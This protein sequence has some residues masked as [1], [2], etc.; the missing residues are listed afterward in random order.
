MR[1]C[2]SS[3]L[4]LGALASVVAASG[5]EKVIGADFSA[6]H[7]AECTL[8][9]PPSAPAVRGAGGAVS[10]VAAAYSLE[11]G[12]AEPAA[13]QTPGYA[14]IGYD[15]DGLCTA[16]GDPP[17]CAPPAW[18]HHPV[19]D[20]PGG[21][22]NALG[23]QIGSQRQFFGA[24][25]LHSAD[26]NAATQRGS[27]APLLVVEVLGYAGLAEDDEVEVRAYLPATLPAG[28]DGGIVAPKWDGTDAFPIFAESYEGGVVT[29]DAGVG[30]AA[31]DGG[32]PPGAPRWVDR[33]A[34]V[35]HYGLVARFDPGPEISLLGVPL[36][37]SHALLTAT[38]VPM[39]G[40]VPPQWELH[41]ALLAGVSPQQGVL[42]FLPDVTEAIV[43]AH[44]CSGDP[45][46]PQIKTYACSFAD[47]S[48]GGGAAC[49]GLSF[50]ISFDLRRARIGPTLTRVRP[51]P[52]RPGEDPGD[53]DCAIPAAGH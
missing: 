20:G 49:D 29:D 47:T 23:A 16:A 19:L 34:Y 46:Y 32:P 18:T 9:V 41:D 7:R 1:T 2:P 14:S 13:G 12:E 43:G 21:R 5:C 44:L 35:T 40:A 53:D 48:L 6:A 52:C 24:S 11:L 38:M 3:A 50:G 27:K 22:D 10:I 36:P 8:V 39:A 17:R 25:V 51:A 42:R 28:A 4:L 31:I 30:D 26:I 37:T 15:L 45:N 33:H